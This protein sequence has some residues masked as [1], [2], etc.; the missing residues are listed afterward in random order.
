MS[1]TDVPLGVPVSTLN[2][3]VGTSVGTL[4]ERGS[5]KRE[6]KGPSGSFP[7]TVGPG[8]SVTVP[9]RSSSSRRLVLTESG[10]YL[11]Q[12]LLPVSE[13]RHKETHDQGL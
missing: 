8:D 12:N 7:S 6:G 4:G 9:S 10:N 2:G 3:P 5:W 13:K 11:V 1:V